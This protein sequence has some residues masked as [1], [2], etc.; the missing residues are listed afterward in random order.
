MRVAELWRYPVK[1]LQGEPLDVASVEADGIA[2][3]RVWALRD[4]ADGKVLTARREPRLLAATARLTDSGMPVIA[5]PGDTTVIGTGPAADA[6]LSDWLGRA[7]TL[8]GADDGRSHVAEAFADPT[9]DGSETLEW[10][11][12]SGRYVDA[13]P[14]LILTTSSIR[15]AARVH[16]AGD[17]TTRRFRPNVV[18]DADWADA[19]WADADWADDRWVEDDWCGDVVRLGAVTVAPQR[20]CM[21]CTMVTRPQPGIVEDRDVFRVLARE[22][23]GRLGVLST[24]L[25]VGDV[26]VGDGVAVMPRQ[27]SRAVAAPTASAPAS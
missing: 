9:D 17:W 7:V 22:H 11:M 12:P 2:G 26:C 8:A 3:D 14:L 24:V 13:M 15:R 4:G 23:G 5:L 10:T 1:S 16:P 27:R 6:A 21:R 18:V 20:P 25:G 19:D